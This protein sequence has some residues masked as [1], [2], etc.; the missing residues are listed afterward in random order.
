[1]RLSN[2]WN[3]DCNFEYLNSVNFYSDC[4]NCPDTSK[5]VNGY[6]T[7]LYVGVA[8]VK[9]EIQRIVALSIIKAGIL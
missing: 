2:K 1:M 3:G 8:W 9:S 5:S 4:D 6:I 7:F